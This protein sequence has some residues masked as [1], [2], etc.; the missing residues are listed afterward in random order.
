MTKTN[1][2]FH[3]EKTFITIDYSAKKLTNRE[4]VRCIFDNCNLSN[5]DLSDNDFMDCQFKN[6]NF[7]MAKLKNT[8]LSK[9]SFT[10]CKI[11]GVDFSECN[12]FLFSFEFKDCV[13]DYST[14]VKTKIK[15]TNFIQ[16]SLKQV[17]F[18][19]TDLTGAAFN[20]CD[21]TEASFIN[22][23]LEKADFST[24]RN[25]SIDPN[26]NK[27]KKAKFS[28]LELAGLLGKYQLDISFD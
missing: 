17:D 3:Q 27:M 9:A 21:L 4:F 19:G 10:G 12:K 5:S 25:F 14:F 20:D 24:A 1:N 23:N 22:S 11:M 2:I 26:I 18:E 15:G 16:T 6:C 28:N 13:L 7:S 8:G